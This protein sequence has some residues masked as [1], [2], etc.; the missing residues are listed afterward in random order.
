MGELVEK[1]KRKRRRKIP[2]LIIILAIL[3]GYLLLPSYVVAICIKMP[4]P[5]VLFPPVGKYFMYDENN[6]SCLEQSEEVERWFESHGIHVYGK[7]GYDC[8]YVQIIVN[9]TG[10]IDY[11][12]YGGN[13]HR[14]ISIDFGWFEMPFDATSMMPLPPDM[15]PKI[16]WFPFHIEKKYDLVIKDEGAWDGN[17]PI[18][19]DNESIDNI[20]IM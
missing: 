1:E 16:S 12:V 7:S 5:Y 19:R 14:W 11:R 6:Y 13:G 3:L 8:D 15:L 20:E 9:E 10:K 18:L 17:T 4:F 2:I